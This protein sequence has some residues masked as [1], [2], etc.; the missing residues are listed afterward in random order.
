MCGDTGCWEGRQPVACPASQKWVVKHPAP[1][2]LEHLMNLGVG[3]R[4][5]RGA[6]FTDVR[7]VSPGPTLL[8]KESEGAVG[9]H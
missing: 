7:A 3:A 4:N 8:P 9:L 6:R 5:W 1:F 2:Q